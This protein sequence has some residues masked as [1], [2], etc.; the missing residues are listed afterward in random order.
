MP[1]REKESRLVDDT[2]SFSS[3]ELTDIWE[4]L[5]AFDLQPLRPRDGATLVR[6][7]LTFIQTKYLFR[8][9]VYS[10]AK[11]SDGRELLG[12]VI[13]IVPQAA[14]ITRPNMLERLLAA[15]TWSG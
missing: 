6:P 15:N 1:I 4:W 5:D 14:A 10:V 9:R 12:S 13:G 3:P 7:P 2:S 8:G 11:C